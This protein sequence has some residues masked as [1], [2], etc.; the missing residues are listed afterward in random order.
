MTGGHRRS[1]GASWETAACFQSPAR[2]PRVCSI[3]GRDGR[4][5]IE[6]GSDLDTRM[7]FMTWNQTPG[8]LLCFDDYPHFS[9]FRRPSQHNSAVNFSPSQI[10]PEPQLH[11][12]AECALLMKLL[13]CCWSA[14]LIILSGPAPS[15][16]N[17]VLF[18]GR[19]L[20]CA[21]VMYLLFSPIS[22]V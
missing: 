1:P 18:L 11:I 8:R 19:L 4:G 21:T 14:A 2:N 3:L 12:L 20:L 17:C 15:S 9:S 6:D 5:Q 16:V 13:L 22:G 7:L 10:P